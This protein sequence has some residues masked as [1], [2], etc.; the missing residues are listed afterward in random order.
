MAKEETIIIRMD[1]GMKE[2]LQKLA[3]ADHRTLSDFIR[4]TL[5]KLVQSQTKAS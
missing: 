2:Q 5:I 4:V 3:K 1:T